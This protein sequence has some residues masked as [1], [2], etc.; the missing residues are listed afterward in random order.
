MEFNDDSYSGDFACFFTPDITPKKI[1]V[2]R[3]TRSLDL[4]YNR[5]SKIKNDFFCDITNIQSS[6]LISP[7]KERGSNKQRFIQSQEENET[8][9]KEIQQMRIAMN[10][11][12]EQL[13]IEQSKAQKL[14]QENK[15]LKKQL[16]EYGGSISRR[17]NRET[18][19]KEIHQESFEI[20]KY[21]DERTSNSGIELQLKFEMTELRV[22]LEESERKAQK[23]GFLLS[24]AL[25]KLQM[26]SY[27]HDINSLRTAEKTPYAPS[28]LISVTNQ[29]SNNI[30]SFTTRSLHNLTSNQNSLYG[31]QDQTDNADQARMV[32][33][34]NTPIDDSQQDTQHQNLIPYSHPLTYTN[35]NKIPPLNQSQTSDQTQFEFFITERCL[36]NVGKGMKYGEIEQPAQIAAKQTA[37]ISQVSVFQ[38]LADQLQANKLLMISQGSRRAKN[39]H[40]HYSLHNKQDV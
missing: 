13:V 11:I 10:D 8:L 28:T 2:Q 25:R 1:A 35:H 4:S 37:Q 27:E 18:I 39:S 33:A 23:L 40:N 14:D 24:E 21:W 36:M 15:S 16:N 9:K 12:E 6:S 19:D 30:P 20:D 29:P 5:N 26:Q 34:P 38:Q 31:H 7:K 17:S 22:R 32:F 3:L